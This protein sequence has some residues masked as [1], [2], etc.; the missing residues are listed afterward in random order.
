[1]WF[2]L[3]V[4]AVVLGDPFGLPTWEA[5]ECPHRRMSGF[6]GASQVEWTKFNSRSILWS[7]QKPTSPRHPGKI[8][9]NLQK[10]KKNSTWKFF[11]FYHNVGLVTLLT[12]S[13]DPP[14]AADVGASGCAEGARGRLSF[15]SGKFSEFFSFSSSPTTKSWRST[16][17]PL[18]SGWAV[19]VGEVVN[20]GVEWVSNLKVGSLIATVEIFF[21]KCCN[22]FF[23]T[24]RKKK[25]F[26]K[27]FEGGKKKKSKLFLGLVFLR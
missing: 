13:R 7:W 20:P 19:W 4:A 16:S 21:L 17:V 2:P 24:W 27:K 25:K 14:R 9:L 12:V 23:S 3:W 18:R 22:F 10:K 5:M 6:T 1:M 15:S 8:G 11:F 26:L